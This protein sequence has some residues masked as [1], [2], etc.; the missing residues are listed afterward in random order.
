MNGL[1]DTRYAEDR[2]WL[3]GKTEARGN[4]ICCLLC[5]TC[6]S[7]PIPPPRG[8]CVMST[9]ARGNGIMVGVPFWITSYRIS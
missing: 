1:G 6:H 5:I 9:E 3:G 8:T 2:R 7:L 4:L